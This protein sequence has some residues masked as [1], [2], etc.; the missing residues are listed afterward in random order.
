MHEA[1]NAN[2]I[3]QH[4]KSI[5]DCLL[6]TVQSSNMSYH[7][8]TVGSKTLISW[9][10]EKTALK[11]N[12]PSCLH[13]TAAVPIMQSLPYVQLQHSLRT[14]STSISLFSSPHYVLL[15]TAFFL[16][17]RDRQQER[18]R[19]RESKR[20]RVCVCVCAFTHAPVCLPKPAAAYT[21]RRGQD[22]RLKAPSQPD[23]RARTHAHAH[24]YTHKLTLH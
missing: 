17:L 23:I 8:S 19:E 1:S 11:N 4:T 14:T 21:S 7:Q 10:T 24:P 13:Q 12:S 22:W 5:S 9:L 3:C 16:R 15:L 6:I 18:E 2:Q 20:E